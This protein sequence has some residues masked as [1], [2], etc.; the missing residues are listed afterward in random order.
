VDSNVCGTTSF[1]SKMTSFYTGF[2]RR[3]T[4]SFLFTGMT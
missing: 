4:M 3:E 2:R 1:R